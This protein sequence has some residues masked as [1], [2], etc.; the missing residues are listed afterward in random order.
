MTYR[1][2]TVK[3]VRAAI[4]VR[5]SDDRAGDAA[6]VGRQEQDARALA[7]RLGWQVGEVVIENDV[8]AFKRRTVTLPDGTTALRVV[9]PGFRRLLELLSLGQVDGLI[10][11]DLDRMAR[12]PRDLEDLVDVIE[13]A[14]VPVESV[15]GSLRLANDSDITMSRVMVAVA[16]KSSRD[17]SRRISRKHEQLAQEGKY[18]GG[19]PRRFGFERDGVTHVP[20]EADAIRW[21][22]AQVID[23]ASLKQT[24]RDLDARG[25]LTVRGNS[26]SSRALSGILSGP[27]VA[28]LRVHRGEVVGAAIWQPILDRDTWEAVCV[29]LKVR[30]NGSAQPQLKRWLNGVLICSLCDEG[31]AGQFQTGDSYRYWCS[32]ERSGCGRIAIHGPKVEAEIERQVLDYLSRPDVVAA[33]VDTTSARGS[34]RARADLAADEAQLKTLARMW[35]QKGV[36]LAEYVE[37][38]KI[39]EQRIADAERVLSS[40][41]PERIRAVLRSDDLAKAWGGLAPA[42]KR[43]VVLALV[44]G[45]RVHPADPSKPR[46]FD[47]T[48]LEVITNGGSQ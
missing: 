13:A 38:R 8:S 25:I 17:S 15:T 31:L 9:R 39:I 14:R 33:L 23:G 7:D 43:E 42:G 21:T 45:W 2:S 32:T 1:V 30:A 46:R 22:A 18:G 35:A 4:L 27:R 6:G 12:D 36:T 19:G 11:Y 16:N 48:R 24:C 28:G 44:K 29:A 40:R 47:P 20:A 5:I 3:P 34:E 26:W 10:A 41:L 37:A